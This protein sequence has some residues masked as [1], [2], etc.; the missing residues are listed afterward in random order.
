MRAHS[1]AEEPD[2]RAAHR[3]RQPRARRP[4][5]RRRTTAL[6]F[7][8]ATGAG[9]ELRRRLQAVG[10]P[11]ARSTQ[12]LLRQ[13][14]FAAIPALDRWL[15]AKPCRA[16]RARAAARAGRLAADG[17]A[18]A[19]RD[20][21]S[22]V[23]AGLARGDASS[24]SGPAL[25]LALAGAAA[26]VPAPASSPATKRSRKL[27]RAAPRGARDDVALAPRR[28]RAHLG[29]PGRRDARCREPVCDRVRARVRGAAARAAARPGGPRRCRRARR[30]RGPQDLR[31]LGGD[32]ARDRRQ[33]RRDPRRTSPTRS[34][35]A[36]GSTASSAPSP[37]RR[38]S[39]RC[40][41]A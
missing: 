35:S 34:A 16:R 6:Q 31:G 40:S 20:A 4:R 28:P 25:L 41:S 13:G 17:G 8:R 12:T 1:R 23:V 24:A 7:A 39:R 11:C 9:G 22:P 33:P 32:P 18:A 29:V 37:P 38:G 21:R 19:R 10:R 27:S 30:Q 15:S 14:R 36:T 2:A 26:A 5:S 3:P